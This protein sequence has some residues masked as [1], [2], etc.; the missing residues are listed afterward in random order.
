M[1]RSVAVSNRSPVLLLGA[2]EG[3]ATCGILYLAS[4]LR[5]NGIEAFVRLTDD[6]H[7]EAELRQSLHLL[8]GHVR[9]RV[10]GVSLKWFHHLARARLMVR[11]LKELDPT[12]TVVLGGN[13]ASYYWDTVA[14]W[15]GVDHV[16]LGDGEGPLLALCRN[17]AEVPNVVARGRDGTV[18]KPPL[19]YIQG[20]DSGEVYYSHFDQLFLSGLDQ[21]S[22]SGWVAPGK[23]CGEN[24]SY[25][26]G[27]RGV[28]KASFGRAKPFLRPVEAVQR[29]HAEIVGRTWQL[30]Y[31][32]SGS[33]G[34]FLARTWA[35][36]DLSRHATTYFLWGVPAKDLVETLCTTFARVFMV[37]DIGCF[38]EAQR[39]E[40][41]KRGL[42][43]PCP[44]DA[45]LF[46]FIEKA[47]RFS[48]LE[49]EISGIA[50]LPFANEFS[51]MQERRL[52]ERVLSAGCTVGYQRLEAQPGALVTEHPARFG[53][54]S[55]ART[56]DEFLEYFER[57]AG[58]GTVPMVRYRDEGFEA[59]VQATSEALEDL[60]REH[61]AEA[62][63]V[64]VEGS[65]RLVDASASRAEVSLGQW[66]GAYRVP[67]RLRAE[68]LT[69][70]RSIDGTGL[71][72]APSV[73]LKKF[74]DS[75]LA[76]GDEA[77]VL[78]STLAMFS[79]PTVVDAAVGHLR[80][81][82]RLDDESAR[83][84]IEQLAAAR[85]LEAK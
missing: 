8:L 45:E 14:Q 32:F 54:V 77:K 67:P 13:T 1:P 49:L 46:A 53:M 28:Q 50:G 30:R 24:C 66:L 51:L 75:S 36:V 65:T 29:D 83:E 34:A 55:E 16:V 2:G 82:A 64:R 63:R 73:A 4:H 22:F 9:P 38:S 69:V 42:L 43:K 71:A 58:S 52:I 27:T 80:A 47:Q 84:L 79:R 3:E 37:L 15:P 35:G 7:T 48:N 44:S 33:T 11:L 85:F 5:R 19:T 12:V 78:L 23:G 74:S 25:C 57:E 26:G 68:P 18:K 59:A 61:A 41:L 70:I 81:K 21:A 40:Q 6:D 39:L 62:R 56:V 76:Q 31:D 72:C 60:I 17:E 20:V 10:V